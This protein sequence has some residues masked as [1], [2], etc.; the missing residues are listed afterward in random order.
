MYQIV[1]SESGAA[2]ISRIDKSTQLEIL[3][4]LSELRKE[5]LETES[6]QLGRLKKGSRTLFRFRYKDYRFYFEKKDKQLLVY[7]VLHKNTFN[8]FFYRSNLDISDDRKFEETDKFW[9]FIEEQ[10]RQAKVKT[11][12]SFGMGSNT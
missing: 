3:S 2:E 1:F 9:K 10:S 11:P 4:E 5:N 6:E 7:H 8:D 12:D